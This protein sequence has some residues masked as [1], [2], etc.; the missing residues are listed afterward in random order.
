[1]VELF[2]GSIDKSVNNNQIVKHLSHLLQ[3]NQ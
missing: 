1:M 2:D 3:I